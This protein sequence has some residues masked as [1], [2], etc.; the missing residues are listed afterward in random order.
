MMPTTQQPTTIFPTTIM[1]S[2]GSNY[3]EMNKTTPP[4]IIQDGSYTTNPVSTTLG[5]FPT[6]TINDQI[7]Q[8]MDYTTMPTL[9]TL[10]PTPTITTLIDTSQTQNIINPTQNQHL[11]NTVIIQAN[12]GSIINNGFKDN[13]NQTLIKVK[14]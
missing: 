7:N 8:N 3:Q 14:L 9:T 12:Q 2:Y 11:I 6:P 5:M 13:Q 10:N 4:T 1:S